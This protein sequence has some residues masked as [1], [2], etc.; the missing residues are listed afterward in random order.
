VRVARWA[1]ARQAIFSPVATQSKNC[2]C[3][4]FSSVM[5]IRHELVIDVQH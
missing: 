4:D 2:F 5:L 3:Q 1:A